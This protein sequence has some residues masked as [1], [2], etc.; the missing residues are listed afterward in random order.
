MSAKA[1][2]PKGETGGGGGGGHGLL[3]GI[4]CSR[5]VALILT[6]LREG[7]YTL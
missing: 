1:R 2:R 5:E 7:V 3:D 4:A 6:E